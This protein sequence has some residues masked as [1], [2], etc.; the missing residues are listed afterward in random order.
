MM[1]A[2]CTAPQVTYFKTNVN[3]KVVRKEETNST[4]KFPAHSLYG[5][6]VPGHPAHDA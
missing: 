4:A 5:I 6:R 2:D 1:V 3:Y